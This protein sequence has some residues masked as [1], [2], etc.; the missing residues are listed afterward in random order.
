MPRKIGGRP[1]MRIHSYETFGAADGPGVRFIVFLSGC[2]FRCRYCHNP[3]TWAK[4]PVQEATPDEVLARA[5]RR[6]QRGPTPV[7]RIGCI[8]YCGVR[9]G[10]GILH[11]NGA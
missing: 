8:G 11:D 3:D 1:V 10:F 9:A 4:P 7:H 6:P 5:L 2:P